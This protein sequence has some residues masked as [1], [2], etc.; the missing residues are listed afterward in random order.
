MQLTSRIIEEMVRSFCQHTTAREQYLFRQALHNLV[1]LAKAEKNQEFRSD[2]ARVYCLIPHSK[3]DD[4][5][6][7]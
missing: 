7:T 2:V 1:F 4:T 6:L 3:L 5:S